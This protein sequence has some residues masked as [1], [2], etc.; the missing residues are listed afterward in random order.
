MLAADHICAE[1]RGFGGRAMPETEKPP[2]RPEDNYCGFKSR[3]LFVMSII[4]FSVY[5]IIY[6]KKGTGA[7]T[8]AEEE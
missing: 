3:T 5:C 8:P 2:A 4:F 6:S 7:N 1:R